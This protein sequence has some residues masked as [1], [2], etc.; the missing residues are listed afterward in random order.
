MH[1]Q[2]QL[3]PTA[4]CWTAT[5][6]LYVGCEQGFLLLADPETHCATIL[7]NPRSKQR[8]NSSLCHHKR[9]WKFLFFTNMPDILF[10][11]QLFSGAD[12]TPELKQSKFMGLTLDHDGLIVIGEVVKHPLNVF[13]LDCSCF[14]SAIKSLLSSFY[15]VF[16]CEWN[17]MFSDCVTWNHQCFEGNLF[18]F[19]GG[20]FAPAEN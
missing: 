17:R 2:T 18:S 5:S 3:T 10:C 13:S 20:C 11:L 9:C 15:F 4:I 7:Y 6:E 8:D 16:S 1:T 12:A 19:A 14:Q